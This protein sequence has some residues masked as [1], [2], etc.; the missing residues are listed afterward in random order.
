MSTFKDRI[1]KKIESAIRRIRNENPDEYS[2]YQH[3]YTLNPTLS[4]NEIREYENYFQIKLPDEYRKYL[5][6]IGNGG[7]HGILPLEKTLQ[8]RFP[9]EKPPMEYL[10]S[11]FQFEES[12]S[13]KDLE[14]MG[15]FKLTEME[16]EKYWIENT[17]GTIDIRDEKCGAFGLLV[18]SGN[19]RG[20]IWHDAMYADMGIY[21]QNLTFWDLIN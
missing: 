17:K 9:K 20:K 13:G 10:K 12:I 16:M 2:A 21:T 7:T 3:R 4:E 5:K 8:R 14:K 11:E 1:L 18:I 19:Q 6:E 15:Y